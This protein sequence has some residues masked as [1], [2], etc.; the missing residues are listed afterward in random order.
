VVCG[1]LSQIREL[2]GGNGDHSQCPYRMHFG[3]GQQQKIDYVEIR[4]P[5]GYVERFEDVKPNQLLR[6]TENTPQPFLAERKRFKEAQIEA[7]KLEAEREK[8]EARRPDNA[9][10][11][12]EPLDWNELQTF[13]KEYLRLKQA[14]T[15][16]PGNPPT[17][18]EFALVLDGRGRRAAALSELEK[19]IQLAPNALL[20]SNTYRTLVRRYGHVYFD[21]SIRF[22][23]DLVEKHPQA[24]MPRLNKALAYV[25]KMPYPKLGIVSQG[26]LSNKSL[27]ELDNI[28]QLDP[29]CWT[30]KFIRG[31]NHLHWPRKLGHAPLAITDFSELIE[32]QKKLPPEKQRDYFAL[33]YVGL[34]D[35]YVKNRDNG[36][37]ENLADARQVWERGLEEYPNEQELKVRLALA[38]KSTD[39]L[40]EYIRKLRGLGDPVDTDLAR[41]WVD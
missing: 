8:R 31:M 24:I 13:K 39:E 9:T 32:L 11:E 10:D 16:D 35:S 17:R 12:E 5:T 40:I 2:D 27:A 21:R 29:Q 34:G 20:Y 6:Y 23:E 4:W 22:F 37:E 14:V 7:R 25:D 18:Y 30:A 1:E 28:L 26:K 19:A 36:L 41:V 38:A 33:G 15:D 3:L